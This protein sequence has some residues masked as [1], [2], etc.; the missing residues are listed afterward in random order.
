MYSDRSSEDEQRLVSET[1]GSHGGEYEVQS[2][3]GCTAV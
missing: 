1:S 2:H 3:V